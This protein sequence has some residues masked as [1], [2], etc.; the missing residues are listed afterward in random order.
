M[1]FYTI[2]YL[3]KGIFINRNE[4][5]RQLAEKLSLYKD[6]NPFVIG[7]PRGGLA[8][9]LPIAK[10]LNS[11]L[12]VVIVR[13]L[14]APQNFELGVG[15][16]AEDGVVFLD[17]DMLDDLQISYSTLRLIEERE[18]QELE[19]RKQLYRN[20]DPLPLLTGKTVIIVDDGLATGVTAHAAILSVKKHHPKKIIFAAPVC[21]AEGL[22]TIRSMVHSVVYLTCPQDL[23][24]IGDYYQNFDQ[25]S[26]E[27][28]LTL[29][30]KSNR[31][32][33]QRQGS[34]EVDFN[35]KIVW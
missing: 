20:G 3:M 13:K 8:V 27:E 17:T 31:D 24:A 6:Q 16:I 28:V 5:G 2:L 11:L 4:A 30:H 10:S 23:H 15:A 7:L 35:H 34:M 33:R 19:R 26:D 21:S 18:H 9:G 25:V 14:G 32:S 22:L 1:Y 29:L 12:D